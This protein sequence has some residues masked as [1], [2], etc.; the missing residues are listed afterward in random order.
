MRTIEEQAFLWLV[1]LTTL[2]FAVIVWP[3]FGAVLWGVVAAI[4]VMPLHRWLVRVTRGREGLS[5]ILSVL[6]V[7]LLGVIPLMVVAASLVAE[8]TGL[9]E[10]IQSGRYDGVGE[11]LRN[12]EQALPAWAQSALERFGLTSFDEVR[13]RLSSLFAQA[14]QIV[15]SRAVTIGQSTFGFVISLA[16]MLYLL[17]FLLRDGERL[18]PRIA[19]AIP[20]RKDDRDAILEKFVV[21]VRATVKG[22]IVIALLQGLL[23]GLIFWMLGIEAPVLWGVLMALLSLL[24]AVGAAIVWLPAA[25]YLLVTGSIWQ[26]VVLITFGV[27]VIGLVDNLLRPKLVGKS[28]RM[29][30]Y[31]VLIST[32]G[33]IAVFG[34]NGFVIGPTIAALFIAVWDIFT[35]SRASFNPTGA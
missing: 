22:S 2:A 27:L 10:R 19:D 14:L 7:I 23:G 1:V 31:V 33:G 29:P 18:V 13:D 17:F 8:A 3:Y 30:D 5:A 25:I 21:V 26:G 16:I 15:A 34:L 12:I 24:P 20:L 35:R 4:I 28:T 32:L 11:Y 6:I 9:Y